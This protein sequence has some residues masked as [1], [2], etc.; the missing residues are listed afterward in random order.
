MVLTK[1]RLEDA[2]AVFAYLL[3]TL[4]VSEVFPAQADEPSNKRWIARTR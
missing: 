1:H 3:K 4:M 2:Q